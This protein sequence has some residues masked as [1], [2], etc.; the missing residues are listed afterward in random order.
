ML[1]RF[2]LFVGLGHSDSDRAGRSLVW[3][4]RHRTGWR[5][6]AL[7]LRLL[8]DVLRVEALF[9]RHHR[10]QDARVLVGHGH[11]RLLPAHAGCYS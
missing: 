6:L 4:R 2:G 8:T 7:G 9:T 10:P 1:D 11:A 3:R 5:L